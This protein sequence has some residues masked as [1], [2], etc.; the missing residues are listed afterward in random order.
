MFSKNITLLDSVNT[1]YSGSFRRFGTLTNR[2]ILF[3]GRLCGSVG[4]CLLSTSS[5]KP[6]GSIPLSTPELPP[7]FQEDPE[8]V[9]AR[10]RQLKMTKITLWVLLLM[11]GTGTSIAISEWGAPAKDD[12]GKEVEDEFSKE[13]TVVAYLKRTWRTI[14]YY[15]QVIK[16]PSSEKLLPEPLEHP[17]YQP[18]YTLVLELTGLLIHP[19][20]SYKTGWR[21]RKRPYLEY[22]VNRVGYPNFEVVIYTK[23]SGWTAFPLINSID[24]EG[25]IMHRLF[26]DATRY[27]EGVHMKDINA[28]NRDKR[29]VIH[30]DWDKAACGTSP[31]NCLVLSKWDGDKNDNAL[32]DLAQFLQAVASEQ[33]SDVRDVLQY[34]AQYDNPLE[35]FREKQRE[36]AELEEQAKSQQASSRTSLLSGWRKRV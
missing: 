5:D 13:P 15:N 19:E 32:F 6:K 8:K 14:R 31:E 35:A 10:A 28:L 26:R 23:E 3:D 17:Y 33:P 11:M 7:E 1:A 2:F 4:L 27:E 22:F 30:V 34:Y 25:R 24:P 20:W 36:L 29:L 21:F 12:S 16:E 9:K 18:K